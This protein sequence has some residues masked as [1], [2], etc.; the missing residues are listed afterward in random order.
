MVS[1]ELVSPSKEIHVVQPQ[2]YHRS[3]CGLRHL[4][5]VL[6]LE[7]TFLLV[8]LLSFRASEGNEGPY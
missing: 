8:G 6:S 4:L 1:V 3:C 2:Q 5:L 7:S